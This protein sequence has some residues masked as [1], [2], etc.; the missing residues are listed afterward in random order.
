MQNTESRTP[1]FSVDRVGFN[2]PN[3]STCYVESRVQRVNE[4]ATF[5]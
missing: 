2:D 4:T 1:I 3:E 5:K